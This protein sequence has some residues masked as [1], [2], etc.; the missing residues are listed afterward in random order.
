MQTQTDSLKN[1]ELAVFRSNPNF[2][3]VILEQLPPQ[4]KHWFLQLGIK[5]NHY[6]ILYPLYSFQFN[7]ISIC[8]NTAL[9]FYSLQQP[10]LLPSSLKQVF[11]DN[12]PGT[13]AKMVLDGIL[14]IQNNGSFISGKAAHPLLYEASFETQFEEKMEKNSDSPIP[15]LSIEALKYADSLEGIDH[16]ALISRMYFYNRIPNSPEWKKIYSSS[17]SVLKTIGLVEGDSFQSRF[18]QKWSFHKQKPIQSGWLS[19]SAKKKLTSQPK[20]QSKFKLYISP[21]PEPYLIRDVF[22]ATADVLGEMDI[23]NFKIGQDVT[24]LLRPDKMVAYFSNFEDCEEAALRIREKISG[25]PAHG[26]PFTADFSNDGLLSWGM[27]PPT[28]NTLPW[29]RSSWRLWIVS[30]LAVSLMEAKLHRATNVKPWKYALDRMQ[31][32]G[33]DPSAWAPP[34]HLFTNTLPGGIDHGISRS[35]NFA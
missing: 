3:V 5:Q 9:L 25:T 2:G 13:I 16:N 35:T 10:S 11:G 28:T 29:G 22:Q 20:S 7:L 21:I 12:F 26:V 23:Q 33:I 24:G 8:K 4:I 19:F 34:H 32:I 6:A 31:A 30:Q 1:M 17:D 27:D 14:E 15:R 18:E